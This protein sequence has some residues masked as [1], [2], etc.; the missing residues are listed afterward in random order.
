MNTLSDPTLP[1]AFTLPVVVFLALWAALYFAFAALE[2]GLRATVQRVSAR[3]VR[4]RLARW[5][6]AHPGWSGLRSSASMV[7]VLALG[8]IA[9][10]AAG[11][12]FIEIAEQFR[13]TTSSLYHA[14]HAVNAWFQNERHPG[15]TALL[16]AVTVAGGP[17]GMALVVMLVAAGLLLRKHPA[18]AVFVMIAAA[19]GALLNLGLKTIFER[20]RPPAATA[21]AVA[22]GYS[23][24]SGHAMGSFIVFGS[25]AYV[26][27]RQ[28]FRW[29]VK[30]ALLA[31]LVTAVLLVGLSRVYLGVHWI[32]DIAGGWSAGAVWLVTAT[33]ALEV[34]LRIRQLRGGAPPLS[35]GSDIPEE[36]VGARQAMV[37]QSSDQRARATPPREAQ[38]R[39]TGAA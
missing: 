15:L 18:S 17:L 16:G 21:I 22:Q 4:T 23:F 13:L 9:A 1:L 38:M 26:V 5:T 25:I 24:P 31:M 29:K 12:A 30:S 36:P 20:V 2:S 6:V 34:L 27:L 32:S 10:F 37:A 33:V 19:G 3:V 35:T 28:P 8:G 14:D 7:L 39:P 11:W